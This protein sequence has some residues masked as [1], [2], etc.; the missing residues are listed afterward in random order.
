[1]GGGNAE[2]PVGK[3]IKI[4]AAECTIGSSNGVTNTQNA[5]TYLMNLSGL[6]GTFLAFSTVDAVDNP[7]ENEIACAAARSVI[8]DATSAKAY[9][10]KNGSWA[11]TTWNNGSFD[12][13]LKAGRKVVVYTY[14]TTAPT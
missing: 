7:I 4:Y 3:Y 9:R 1:M 10:Y 5:Q 14:Q 8:I 6:S 11:L 2:L 12:A 13:K